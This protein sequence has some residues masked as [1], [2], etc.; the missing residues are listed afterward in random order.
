MNKTK[1]NFEKHYCMV[2][3]IFGAIMPFIATNDVFASAY[4]LSVSSSGAQNIDITGVGNGTAISAD[5]ITVSTTCRYGYNF[6]ISTSV[7]NNNLYLGG[8][9]ANNTSG[10]YFTPADGTTTLANS[11]NTWGYYYNNAAPTTAPT[12][13]N[14]FNAVP[15]LGSTAASI[16]TPLPSPAAADISDSFNIYYGVSASA[17]MAKGTY[18]MIPDANN[19]NNDGTIVYATTIANECLRYTVHFDST[20]T[21]MGTSITGTGTVDDQT[22]YEGTPANLTNSYFTGPTVGGTTYYFAGWNTAQDGSGTQYTKGQSVTDLSLAG[23]TITLYAQWTDCPGGK[24]CYEANVAN[25]NDVEG[26]MGD[27]TISSSATSVILYAPNFS[28]ADYGFVAWNTKADGTGTNYGPNQTLEFNAG[29][30]SAGGI[31][32]YAKWIVS[33]GNMQNWSGCSN[34]SQGDVTALKDIRD[35]DVYAVAKLADGKCWMIEN[36]RLADKDSSNN[37]IILSSSNTHNPSLPLTNSWWYSSANDN[38]TKPTSNHLSA[39]VDPTQ[40]AWCSVYTSATNCIDQSMLNTD[41]TTLFTNNVASNYNAGGNVYSYGNYYNWYSATAG[42]G[43]YSSSSGFNASGDIC[44]KGWHLPTGKD[45]TSEFGVLDINL[46][47][48]G[49]GA[50][51]NAGKVLSKTYRSYP[52]NFILPGTLSGSSISNRNSSGSYCSASSNAQYYNYSWYIAASQAT[53]SV[54]YKYPG[55]SVRCIAGT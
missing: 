24:I 11:T 6:T 12:T 8:N 28:R 20:G 55:K 7:N 40:T 2:F 5:N 33:A 54:H 52:N 3:L 31:K 48:T 30:Y 10:T 35:N 17:N 44:P 18:K 34:M 15:A 4:S 27:Q 25:P 50:S 36:L 32:L 16:K 23:G 45:A 22:M 26:E 21:N 49:Q 46:G 42:H 47:G 53:P 43:R 19:S 13:S 29:A 37:D 38:D 51:G 41:N 39:S 1:I 14:T 9:S